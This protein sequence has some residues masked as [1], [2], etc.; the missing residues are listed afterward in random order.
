[1]WIREKQYKGAA[2]D[3]YPAQV[4]WTLTTVVSMLS[5]LR[6]P[7]RLTGSK[8]GLATRSSNQNTWGSRTYCGARR[9]MD[10][11]EVIGMLL[12]QQRGWRRCSS[13]HVFW[14]CPVEA[15]RMDEKLPA[16]CQACHASGLRRG[17]VC[18]ECQGKGYRMFVNGS[19]TPS[20]VERPPQLWR[21]QRPSQHPR[22]Q[23][24]R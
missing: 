6:L 15:L 17:V 11:E 13:C 22:S 3:A 10:F 12:D 4:Y 21:R 14:L 7:R 23:N 9:A 8:W 19:Q 16:P 24:R 5:P 2:A 20:R 18:E 1:M